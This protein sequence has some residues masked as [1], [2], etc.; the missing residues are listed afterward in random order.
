MARHPTLRIKGWAACLAGSEKLAP[1]SV[2][3]P[4][5]APVSPEVYALLRRALFGAGFWAAPWVF[6]PAAYFFWKR[7]TRP[8]V[9]MIFCFPVKNG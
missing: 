7:S 2:C 6:P 3:S 1:W 4:A 9:S 8:S 5:P